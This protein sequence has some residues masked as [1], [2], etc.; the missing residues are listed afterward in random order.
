MRAITKPPM[1]PKGRA[2]KPSAVITPDAQRTPR[3][4]LSPALR[5]HEIVAQAVLFFAEFGFDGKTRA[6]AERLG[7]TQPLLYRYFP[8]KEALIERVYQDVFVGGWNPFWEELIRDREK[9]IKTRLTVFYQE[10]S[11]IIM[12]CE[13][14]RL[15]MFSGLK[16]LDYNARYL[17]FLRETIFIQIIAELRATY[18]RPGLA[19]LPATALEI[20]AIWGLHAGIFYLGVRKWIYMMPIADDIRPVIEMKVANFLDGVGAILAAPVRGAA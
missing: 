12:T 5:E 6:L 2:R 15:F 14:V 4:R 20:E 9:T 1:A 10:Y 3:R 7:I 16:G 18:R 19:E 13:W 11:K 17:R 8:S